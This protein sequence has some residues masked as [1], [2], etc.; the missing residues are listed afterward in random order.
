M[1][2]F[3]NRCFG[4]LRL[5]IEVFGSE[6]SLIRVD[7]SEYG[8]KFSATKMIGSPPG[9]VGYNEGGQLTEKVR[10]KPYSLV[11]FDE[12]EKAHPDIFHSLL[13]LLDEGFMTDG[14]GR[15][16]NF[17]NCLIV[18]TS[19]IGMREVEE[20]GAGVGFKTNKD[21]KISKTLT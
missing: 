5:A 12:V 13:Q 1:T 21:I 9:Y 11:L 16:I 3:G 15:K 19:N 18:M 17:R 10:R 4:S 6:E 20:F 14:M 2:V 8:E 7:M